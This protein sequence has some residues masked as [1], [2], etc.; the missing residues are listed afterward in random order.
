MIRTNRRQLLRTAGLGGL[1]LATPAIARSGGA[2]SQGMFTHGVASG[3]PLTNRVIL[4]TRFAT[5]DGSIG[6]LGWELAE[7]EAFSRVAA[8]GEVTASPFNDYC[9]KVDAGGLAP[10]R[11]FFYRFLS[12]SG[13]SPIGRTRTAPA[14]G[15]APLTL[16][17]FSCS[18]LP[19]GYFNAY[20]NAAAREDVDL[21]VHVGDYIY[22]YARGTYPSEAQTVRGW[23]EPAGEIVRLGD[24]YARY[25]SYRA[26]PDLQEL[27]RVKPF[28]TV[29]DDHELTNNT[30]WE[31]AQNHQPDTEGSWAERRVAA[32]KAYSDWMPIRTFPSEPLR[33]YRTLDWGQTASILLLDARLIGR[34]EQL[35]WQAAIGVTTQDGSPAV[36][37]AINALASGPLAD[38][39]RSLLGAKQEAWLARQL[40]RAK[41][42][43]AAWSILAQQVV[44]ARQMGAADAARLLPD[45]ASEGSRRFVHLSGEL[46]AAGLEWNLDAWGGYPAARARL[47][48]SLAGF[49]PQVSVLA[50]DS[51]NAWLSDLANAQGGLAGVEFAGG[52][53]SSPGFER[54]LSKAAP[55]EREAIMRAANPT[56]KFA[57]IT[58]RGY[59]VL[60]YTPAQLQAEWVAMGPEAVR[61]DRAAKTT[62]LIAAPNSGQGWTDG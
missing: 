60:R 40:L 41:A 29:W 9:A 12:A 50:G 32:F 2:L 53:V 16:A 10:G 51:H 25:R 35:D 6:R 44:M 24:Y 17:L 8:R 55:G 33:I 34:D 37:K 18:N 15:T 46:G 52:S 31:G 54:T 23:L 61:S 36:R 49:G 4:W 26:D 38:P 21:C 42:R 39:R 1:G 28:A 62:R 45:D 19:F 58:H 13:A 59:G 14:G 57:D 43:G 56:L 7:D 30:W 48:Q 20:A 22:E 11:P 27:H 3:D 5:P 47:M